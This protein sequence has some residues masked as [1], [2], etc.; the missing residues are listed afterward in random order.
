MLVACLLACLPACR[1]NFDPVNEVPLP[2]RF[3]W[4]KVDEGKAAAAAG[5][6]ASVLAQDRKGA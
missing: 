3:E 6:G 5:D 1:Y 2:G 4:S